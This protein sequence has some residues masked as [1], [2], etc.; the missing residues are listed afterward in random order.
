VRDSTA[1]SPRAP[2][3]GVTAAC[4]PYRA[5]ELAALVAAF[6]DVQPSILLKL[7]AQFGRKQHP[8]YSLVKQKLVHLYNNYSRLLD[9]S[10][11]FSQLIFLMDANF[12]HSQLGLANVLASGADIGT[13][14]LLREFSLRHRSSRR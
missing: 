3:S 1:A 7:Y 10:R 4:E 2:H 13:P 5:Q 11:V 14:A 6:S 8:D 12:Q 9:K